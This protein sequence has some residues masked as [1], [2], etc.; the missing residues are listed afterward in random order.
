MRTLLPFALFAS[1]FTLAACSGTPTPSPRSTAQP[2]ELTRESPIIALIDNTPVRVEDLA[3]SLYEL[4]GREALREAALDAA[5]TDR[6][7]ARNLTVTS[8]MIAREHDLFESRI[9]EASSSDNAATLREQLYRSRNLGPV[10]REALFRR[11]AALRALVA[12][13]IAVSPAE[14][15]LA[16][17]LA[18][19][20]KKIARL[21]LLQNERDAAEVRST[22]GERPSASDVARFAERRSIDPT[23]RRGGQLPPIHL[24]DPNYPIAVRESL[25]TLNTGSLS[26][27]IPLPEGAAL[28]Y[29]EADQSAIPQPADAEQRLATELRVQRERAE[30][31]RLARSLVA[32][33]RVSVLDRSL[34]WSWDQ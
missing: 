9:S 22:L 34:G 6:L 24:A 14:I 20:P 15:E 19:G 17:E 23:A 2:A 13:Q 25:R 8:A 1:L 5:L 18:Y 26:A 33:S 11:N 28:I 27:I 3:P 4:A 31:D 7:A 10:R 21:I 30:M 32:E 16:V 29:L 12:D